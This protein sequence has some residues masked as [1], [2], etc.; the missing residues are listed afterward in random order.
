MSDNQPKDFNLAAAGWDEKPQRRLLAAAVAAGISAAIPLSQDM[1]VL[2]YGC[3]TGLVGLQL[4]QKLGHLTAAD[5]A[6]GM[7]LELRK[8]SMALGIDNVSPVLVPEDRNILPEAGFELAFT[9]MVLH[10]IEDTASLLKQFYFTVA[11][12]G[13]IAIADL[14]K[15]DG[16]FHDNPN[17]I[18]HQGFDR[19][20][21]VQQLSQLGFVD[22]KDQTIHTIRKE[23][24]SGF[25]D[26]PVFLIT[27]RKP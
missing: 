23:R 27:G 6:H 5:T 16:S 12:N 13:Y 4:A 24:G 21:L 2:E 26:Y 15:E 14:E 19:P 22:I 25:A 17:G 1:Q 3:G 18:A 8:K 20:S 7:L 10:H 11:P 9:S